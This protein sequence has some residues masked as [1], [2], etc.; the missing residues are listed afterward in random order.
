LTRTNTTSPAGAGLEAQL[1]AIAAR[2]TSDAERLKQAKAISFATRTRELA[3]AGVPADVANM[4]LTGADRWGRPIDGALPQVAAARDLLR[5]KAL[6]AVLIGPPGTGK[7]VAAALLF[8]EWSKRGHGGWLCRWVSAVDWC[9]LADWSTERAH[10]L[11]ADLL[12]VDDIGFEP[13]RSKGKVEQLVYARHADGRQTL[14]TT[15]L[16]RGQLRERYDKRVAGA[17]GRWMEGVGAVPLVDCL[18]VLR[19]KRGE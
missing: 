9:A 1:A 10:Y 18:D 3:S 17:N 19:P 11:G 16:S 14:Y 15:N 2:A 4:L 5:E 6:H 13:S 7:T 12:V 8:D